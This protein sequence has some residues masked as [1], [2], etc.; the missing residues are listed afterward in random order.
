MSISLRRFAIACAAAFSLFATG[1]P[2]IAQE[3]APEHLALARQYVD[4]TDKSA[5]YE[6]T[7]VETGIETMRTILRQSPE[8]GDQAEAAI[9]EV[10]RSYQGRKGELLDQFARLYAL[11]FSM[12]ELRQIVEFYS[13]PV[14]SKLAE[15]NSTISEDMQS[16][17][18]VFENNL[19]TEFFAQVRAALR[20]Q[21]I[22]I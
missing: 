6:V 21:G 22:D 17:F 13:S 7:I 2:A 3:L 19:K 8:I 15:T 5:I 20:T 4:L 10:I 14:G 11:R 16:V 18:G 1:V 9:G 12:E